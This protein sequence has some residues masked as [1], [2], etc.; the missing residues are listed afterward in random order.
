MSSMQAMMSELITNQN[1]LIKQLQSQSFT[2]NL[3]DDLKAIIYL[4]IC[5]W[6]ANGVHPHKLEIE[7]FLNANDI[8]VL[9]I[10]E[11]H[12]TDMYNFK[13]KGFDFYYTKHPMGKGHG[14]T[15]ILIKRNIPVIPHF[16]HSVLCLPNIQATSICFKIKNENLVLYP[17]D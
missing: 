11:T 7:I 5:H 17:E 13:I 8:D 15:G 14:G 6:N 2:N 10:S 4:Q 3:T 16:Y 12:L 9:L 1:L